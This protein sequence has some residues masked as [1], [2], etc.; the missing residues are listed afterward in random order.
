[1][2]EHFIMLHRG[3]T[4][5]GRYSKEMMIIRNLSQCYQGCS[6][7]IV[8]FSTGVSQ[9]V[10]SLREEMKEGRKMEKMVKDIER[11][12]LSEE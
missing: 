9:A 1:M 10:S 2:K 12:L 8:L 4:K 5:E 3:E 11:E 7:N 6:K